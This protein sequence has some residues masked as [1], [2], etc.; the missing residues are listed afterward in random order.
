MLTKINPRKRFHTLQNKIE[1]PKKPFVKNVGALDVDF[2]ELRLI[3]IST[4]ETESNSD[5]N[6]N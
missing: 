4:L 3:T 2:Y 6:K 1:H 5:V